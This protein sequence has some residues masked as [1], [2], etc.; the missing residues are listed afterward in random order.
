VRKAFTARVKISSSELRAVQVYLDGRRIAQ[1]TG[2]KSFSVRVKVSGLQ[3]GK[4]R[5]LVRARDSN[6]RQGTKSSAFRICGDPP[7]R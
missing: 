4:H 7:D 1:H 5:V 6:G 2:K 3:P